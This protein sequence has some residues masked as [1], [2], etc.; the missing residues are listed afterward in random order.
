M[1]VEVIRVVIVSK[2]LKMIRT[3]LFG[4]ILEYGT[5]VVWAPR[6]C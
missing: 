2:Y 5:H 4:S 3:S 1:D 6:K